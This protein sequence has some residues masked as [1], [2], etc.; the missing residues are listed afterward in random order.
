MY[1]LASFTS[2]LVTSLSANNRSSS[3]SNKSFEHEPQNAYIIESYNQFGTWKDAMAIRDRISPGSVRDD[4]LKSTTTSVTLDCRLNSSSNRTLS[5]TVTSSLKTKPVVVVKW[6]RN[7]V[8]IDFNS[9]LTK[10]N[11]LEEI[12]R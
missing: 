2:T 3:S 6:L 7:D 1:I 11:G 9:K 12:N 10:T 4:E 8:Q 5:S